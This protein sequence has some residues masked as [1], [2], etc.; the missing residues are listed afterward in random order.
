LD[1][2]KDV[3]TV[4]RAA[5]KVAELEPRVRWALAGDGQ[6]RAA[7]EA[8]AAELGIQDRVLF[9]GDITEVPAF[10][11]HC[12]VG[13]LTP[14]GNEGLSNTILE[15]MAARLPVVATDCGGN[16][17]LVREGETGYVVPIG[18][19]KA[20]ADAVVALVRQPETARQY[21][22]NGRR[23]IES[24]HRPEQVAARFAALYRANAVRASR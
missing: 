22:A 12:R 5:A 2:E 24:T 11:Q 16:K 23:V 19:A 6:E 13:V 14:S 1:P 18:D 20:L 15:Y 4:L 3:G 10:L 9:L 17:E 21:G 8:L 7:L